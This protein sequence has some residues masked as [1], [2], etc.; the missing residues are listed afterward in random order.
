MFSIGL[1]YFM[2]PCGQTTQEVKLLGCGTE[3]LLCLCIIA[4]GF[5]HMM[6]FVKFML[7]AG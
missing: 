1:D 7:A 5:D 6:P 3:L 4:L 2:L